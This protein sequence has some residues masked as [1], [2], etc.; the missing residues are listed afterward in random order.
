MEVA[1]AAD[2]R[3]PSHHLVDVR[4]ELAEQGGVLRVALDE[5]IARVVVV[6]LDQ[7]SVLGEVVQSDDLVAGLEQLRDEVAVD[8]AGCAGDEDT[9]QSRIPPPRAPQTSTTSLPPMS[10][11]R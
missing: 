7:A 4:G 2:H 3:P 11:F 1:D 6:G 5:P 10:R 9:H 8:E